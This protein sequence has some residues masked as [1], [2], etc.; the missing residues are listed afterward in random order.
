M[1]EVI[2]EKTEKE[3]PGGLGHSVTLTCTSGQEYRAVEIAF[4]PKNK[5]FACSSHSGATESQNRQLRTTSDHYSTMEMPLEIYDAIF[6]LS[7]QSENSEAL[8]RLIQEEMSK[9]P[10]LNLFPNN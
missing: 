9:N 5:I 7:D 8:E 3:M 6:S 2:I 4:T 1:D 10:L